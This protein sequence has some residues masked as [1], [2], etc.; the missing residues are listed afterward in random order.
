MLMTA[1]TT[2]DRPAVDPSAG[3]S[4]DPAPV[5]IPPADLPALLDQV[6]VPASLRDRVSAR[7]HTGD[8]TWTN[9]PDGLVVRVPPSRTTTARTTK[10]IKPYRVRETSCTCRGFFARHGCY[11]PWLWAVIHAWLHPPLLLVTG[12]AALTLEQPLLL[13]ALHLLQQ[14]AAGDLTLWLGGEALV[15]EFHTSTATDG[16]ITLLGQPAAAGEATAC[17]PVAALH[18]LIATCPADQPAVTLVAAPSGLCWS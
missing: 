9:G 13:A 14:H 2:V 10:I 4:A 11:H 17:G 3:D 7:L 5:Q 6:D 8:V 15:L 16:Q 12:S 18:A 1:T